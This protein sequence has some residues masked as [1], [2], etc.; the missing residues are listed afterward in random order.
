MSAATTGGDRSSTAAPAECSTVARKAKPRRQGEVD[1]GCL[2]GAVGLL[3]MPTLQPR[4]LPSD[5]RTWMKVPVEAKELKP[6]EAGDDLF[7]RLGDDAR[8][9]SR[10]ERPGHPATA[11]AL[12]Q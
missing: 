12:A 1:R 3:V 5:L 8:E 11:V 2:S 9:E 7:G 6:D 4:T 10:A